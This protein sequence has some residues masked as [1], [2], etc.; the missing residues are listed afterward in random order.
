MASSHDWLGTNMTKYRRYPSLV[1]IHLDCWPRINRMTLDIIHAYVLGF[2][3]DEVG[4][5]I[6]DPLPSSS[7]SM[8]A[9]ACT[10]DVV[11]TV[12]AEA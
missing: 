9:F 6:G 10:D 3:P 12:S 11:G 8:P 2:D 1:G 7:T 4:V 5:A